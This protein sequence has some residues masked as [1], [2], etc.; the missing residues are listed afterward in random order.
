[1]A[2]TIESVE[3]RQSLTAVAASLLPQLVAT[4]S[5]QRISLIQYEQPVCAKVNEI[6][7]FVETTAS[8]VACPVSREMVAGILREFG[9]RARLRPF[10]SND[11]DGFSQRLGWSSIERVILVPIRNPS[12]EYGWLLAVNRTQFAENGAVVPIDDVDPAQNFGTFEAGLWAATASFLASH[13]HNNRLFADQE[14]LL[15][16]IVSAMVRAIDAKDHYTKGHSDRVSRISKVLARTLNLSEQDRE[17]V[18]LAG[19]LHDI[20]KI[21]VPDEILT[22]P[23]KLTSDEFERLKEHPVIGYDVLRRLRK[24]EFVLGGVRHH[25]ESFD[26]TGYPDQLVGEEIPLFARIIAVA[27]ALDAMTSNRP[28]RKGRTFRE[29]LPVLL[30]NIGPQWDPQVIQALVDARH[31]I[32]EICMAKELEEFESPTLSIEKCLTPRLPAII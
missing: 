5:A 18:A 23:G 27:D 31:E 2:E 21:G 15:L 9:P 14:E 19:L 10:V 32:S 26:G 24:L 7:E 22:K 4:I 11:R 17:Q 1:L 25:H 13:A 16:G 6:P 3:V 20:G 30:Q 8:S 29:M 28:Y 12:E